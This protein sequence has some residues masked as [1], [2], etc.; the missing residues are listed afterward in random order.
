[1]CAS[2]P[3]NFANGDTMM[4]VNGKIV[5]FNTTAIADSV[6]EIIKLPIGAMVTGVG[7]DIT[8]AT[9]AACTASLGTQTSPTV[10]LSG[11]SLAVAARTEPVSTANATSGIHA[12][13]ANLV[14]TINNSGGA[15]IG[16]GVVYV[17]Y[18]VLNRATEV[19]GS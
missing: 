13:G 14:L 3:F 16:A 19:T 7:I 10:F 2:F 18:Y 11:T 4:N 5:P 9:N 17:Q 1:M 6:F 8:G 15:T 12:T